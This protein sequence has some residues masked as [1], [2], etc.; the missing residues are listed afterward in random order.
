MCEPREDVVLVSGNQRQLELFPELISRA[1][2][3]SYLLC[4]AVSS[5]E[6]MSIALKPSE[7]M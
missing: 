4:Q 1:K 5:L 2:G 6:Q 3:G 7:S